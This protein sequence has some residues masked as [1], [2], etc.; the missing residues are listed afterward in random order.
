MKKGLVITLVAGLLAGGWAAA[1]TP[2]PLRTLRADTD[3]HW[4]LK[5][6]IESFTDVELDEADQFDGYTATAEATIPFAD[7]FRLRIAYPFK[8]DGDATI[9]DD[10]PA[11]PGQSIDIEGNGGVYDFLTFTFEH[12][13]SFAEEKGY[14]LGWYLGGGTKAD[15]LE[16]T[17][18]D[19]W[20]RTY[21]VFNHTGNLIHGGVRYDRRHG[22]GEVLANLG[23]RY[24]FDSDDIYPGGNKDGFLALDLRAA[25]LFSPWH[26][27]YPVIELTYLGDL[28]DLNQLSLI[29]Q[30]LLSLGNHLELKA[31]AVVGLGGTGNQLG[32]LAQMV[33]YF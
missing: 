5:L 13:L 18:Y 26:Q 25:V 15:R 6:G 16:T 27:L 19:P 4:E 10:Q 20:D 17:K 11:F 23:A 1:R 21:D 30:L 8:T 33:V 31:G 24:Y 22:F 14:D 29:P 28:S 7:R 12:Q 2:E 9:K 32:G 3:P